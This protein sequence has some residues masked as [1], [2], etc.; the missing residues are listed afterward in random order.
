[1][2]GAPL[3]RPLDPSKPDHAPAL[4]TPDAK[5]PFPST[6]RMS[7]QIGDTPARRV[8]GTLLRRP[9]AL[10][11]LALVAIVILA[12]LCAP[13]LAPASPNE[14]RVLQRLQAPAAH[15]WFGTDD[16][17]RDIFSRVLYGARVS[18]LLG[19][20]VSS[21]CLFVGGFIG[22]VAGLYPRLDNPLMRVMDG[23]MAFP[24]IALAIILMATL[25]AS[26]TNIMIALSITYSPRMARV[27][28]SVVL[29]VR[30]MAYIE[31]AQALGVRDV[32][33]LWCHVLPNCLSP[34]V[35]QWTF[36]FAYAILGEASLS[37][38][39]VGVPAEVPTWGTILSEGRAY[40]Q[41]A[42]W[43]TVLPGLTVVLTVLGLNLLGDGLR[44]AMDPSMQRVVDVR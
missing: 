31:A 7:V 42:P 43:M 22:L 18:L 36:I 4:T 19:F 39:G 33:L 11:G 26:V 10:G 24:N 9:S 21:L 37:F 35:V 32:R 6:D 28:R 27:V 2:E 16:L 30:E 20:A 5:R 25:G 29:V 15:Q 12:A 34:I 17:G 8:A 38:L 44:D 41:R 40:I 23:F 13:W 3:K 14:I 1:M